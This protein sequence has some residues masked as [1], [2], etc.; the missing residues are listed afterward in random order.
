LKAEAVVQT[1]TFSAGET[2][3][4]EADLIIVGAGAAGAAIAREFA[5]APFS[6]LILESGVDQETEAHAALNTV[7]SIGA[8]TSP[9]QIAKRRA[10]HA[11]QAA[12][13]RQ[14]QQPFGVR[15]RVVGGS[16]AAWAGKSAAF[17]PID[18]AERPW[19]AHTGWPFGR[20]EVGRYLDRAGEHLNLGP[21]LYGADFWRRYP[22]GEPAP[23]FPSD[24]LAPFFWQFARSRIDPLDVMRLGPELARLTAPNVRLLTDATVT[25]VLTD[26]TATHVRGVKIASLNGRRGEV[27]SGCVVLAASG[28]ENPRLL[29]A[30]RAVR[31][32]G[33][34]N[35]HDLVGRFLMDH[36]G[37]RIAHFGPGDI[38]KVQRRFGFFGLTEG[39]RTHMYMHGLAL[40]PALQ[41]REGLLNAALYVMA[42]NAPDDPWPALK[43]LLKG[44][45]R[46]FGADLWAVM[47]SPGL[48]FTG[49][50]M[51][52]LQS[53]RTP[54]PVKALIVNA[55][56]ALNPNFVAQ[57][58]LSR[59]LP[60]KV[61]GLTIDAIS[62]Q[63]PHPDSRITLS[64]TLDPL[65]VPRARIAWRL[66]PDAA[67]TLR[68]LALLIKEE[69]PKAGLPTPILEPWVESG[70]LEDAVIIDMAHT[71]GATRMADRPERGV[72]NPQGE[73]FGVAGLFVAGGSVF[74]TS[75]HANPTLMITALAVRLADHLKARL[76]QAVGQA[77]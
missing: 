12:F 21:H 31:P 27:R 15:C 54:D 66:S 30:S 11:A 49:I 23:H 9:A 69:F 45:W 46:S 60:H 70:R 36:P 39:G 48:F 13:W 65:G 71:L 26:D 42:E 51:K 7:E 5:G 14:E 35:A 25:E 38:A 19:A 77:A 40:S 56:I 20:D 55:A 74:P 3:A 43:R 76:S 52:I 41:E 64:E 17:D 61:I 73:V 1:A 37:A 24:R 32:E 59:G 4:F 44:Q 29:L 63:A 18:F 34:G 67:Q 75:G 10:F 62:E 16:T 33:L 57:E 6:V 68:R 47:K 2:T 53:Q 72:V 8:P 58:F 50:G 22:G 28:I